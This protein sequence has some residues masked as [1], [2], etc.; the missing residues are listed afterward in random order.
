V[1]VVQPV[2]G[3][4]IQ[5]ALDVER[6]VMQIVEAEPAHGRQA[7]EAKILA[8]IGKPCAPDLFQVFAAAVTLPER[9]AVDEVVA[10]ADL[11]AVGRRRF[12]LFRGRE[13]AVDN[14]EMD[15]RELPGPPKHSDGIIPRSELIPLTLRRCQV[16]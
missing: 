13:N 15:M 5:T 10:D 6:D 4:E 1:G 8:V 16:G 2:E 12:I 11:E 14:S 7:S 9:S 3:L